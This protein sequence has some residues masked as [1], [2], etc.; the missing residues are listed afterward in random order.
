VV[1][2]VSN[3][4][5][6]E[7][8]SVAKIVTDSY[9]RGQI[10]AIDHV[11]MSFNNHGELLSILTP[12]VGLVLDG[13]YV[14]K[15]IAF[16][17]PAPFNDVEAIK[18]INEVV[19]TGDIPKGTK[20]SQFTSA[21]DNFG[22]ALGI[23][24]KDGTKQLNTKGNSFVHDLER[25]LESQASQGNESIAVDTVVKNFTGLGGPNDKNYGTLRRI[26]R[27]ANA[28]IQGVPIRDHDRPASDMDSLEWLRQCRRAG[29]YEQGK[30]IYERVV[31]TLRTSRMNSKSKRKTITG[32]APDVEV[33]KRRNPSERNESPKRILDAFNA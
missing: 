12:L 15:E 27:F 5:R 7:I 32:F 17:A 20:P 25:W 19:K 16:D 26:K 14:S 31:S 33:R 2:W 11:G 9:G 29:L 8:G 28:L 18:V 1:Q 4:L 23:M 3:R 21:A 10:S 30:A 6:D 13:V 24:K 22:Y